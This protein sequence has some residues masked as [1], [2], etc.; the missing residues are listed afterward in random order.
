MLEHDHLKL[1]ALRGVLVFGDLFVHPVKQFSLCL[2]EKIFRGQ[3]V[4]FQ[5]F[6][7]ESLLAFLVVETI[8]KL[9]PVL[10][11]AVQAVV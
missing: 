5:E 7:W 9:F 1:V 3:I 8:G 2:C 11:V 10:I 6:P 4:F